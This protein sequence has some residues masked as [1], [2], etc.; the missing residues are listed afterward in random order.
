[1]LFACAW[2][3]AGYGLPAGF[4]STDARPPTQVEREYQLQ[5][6]PGHGRGLMSAAAVDPRARAGLSTSSAFTAAGAD[7]IESGCDYDSGSDDEA[8]AAPTAPAPLASPSELT[9]SR[10]AAEGMPTLDVR[11]A[12]ELASLMLFICVVGQ[13]LIFAHVNGFSIIG[14]EAPSR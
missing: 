4:D 7:G 1:M 3:Q 6:G 9:T 14:F 2:V 11:Q 10:L 5:R 13:P 12:G 8:G